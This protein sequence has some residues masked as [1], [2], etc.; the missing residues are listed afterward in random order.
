[1]SLAHHTANPAAA[2]RLLQFLAERRTTPFE[3]GRAD[4][5]MLAFDAV[6]AVTGRDPAADLRGRYASALQ[7]FRLLRNMGGLAGLV[8]SRF[9]PAVQWTEASDGDVVLLRSGVCAGALQGLG[10]LGIRW[11]GAV[12]GQGTEGLVIVPGTVVRGCWK[13]A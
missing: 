7:A 3:W 9:G 12:V 1:M 6:R 10:A 11:R 2:H 13:V 4:C 5:A 8:R